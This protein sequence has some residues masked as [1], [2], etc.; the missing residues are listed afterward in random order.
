V[1]DYFATGLDYAAA[2]RAVFDYPVAS[3][4]LELKA[5]VLLLYGERALGWMQP[6]A[7]AALR[8]ARSRVLR[9][10]TD[11]AAAEAPAAFAAAVLDFAAG[12]A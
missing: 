11:F 6:R 12:L 1:A 7:R 2:Y 9:G 3:R 10:A 8:E 4:I 5:S